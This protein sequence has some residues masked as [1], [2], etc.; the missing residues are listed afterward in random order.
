M[1][2]VVRRHGEGRKSIQLIVA[3]DV[4][5]RIAEMDTKGQC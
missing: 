5:I 2:I 4:G 1:P 3:V